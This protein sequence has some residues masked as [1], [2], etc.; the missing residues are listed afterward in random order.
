MA[1]DG[2]INPLWRVPN[3]K[4]STQTITLDSIGSTTSFTVESLSSFLDFSPPQGQTPQDLTL[5]FTPA[6]I[7]LN[8]TVNATFRIA[9]PSGSYIV[10]ILYFVA[11]PVVL[12]PDT[13]SQT[14]APGGLFTWT[15]NTSR[16]D[17]ADTQPPPW[18]LTLGSCTIRVNG[19]PVPIGSITS[20][21]L[22]QS[23]EPVYSIMAQM[24]YDVPLGSVTLE[25]ED[26]NGRQGRLPVNVRAVLPAW[27]GLRFVPAPS[28]KPYDPLTL[29]FTGLGATDVPAPLGD[30]ASSVIQPLASLEAFVGG[31]ST[32][33]SQRAALLHCRR[34]VRYYPR[35]AAASSGCLQRDSE[36]RRHR[37]RRRKRR[38]Y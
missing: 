18:P 13:V 37:D 2:R 4:P 8:Q 31:R 38:R 29:N 28:R 20:T 35:S 30:L 9:I 34:R 17:A 32:P 6:G 19:S 10:T 22:S 21:S 1:F 7:L 14:L 26:K 15:A 24:P 25:I 11:P 12:I 16:C 33:D 5:T 27:I 23:F 36:N 3:S